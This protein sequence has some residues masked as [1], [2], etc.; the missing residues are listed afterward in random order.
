MRPSARVFAR[1]FTRV[2]FA[3]G[4]PLALSVTCAEP[5]APISVGS[6]LVSGASTTVIVGQTLQLTAEVHSEDNAVLTDR[7]VAWSANPSSVATVSTT[8]LVTTLV[9][10]SVTVTATAG[11]VSGIYNITVVPIPVATVEVTPATPTVIVGATQQLTAT[12][13]SGTGAALT[14]RVVTW[15]SATPATATVSATGLV[16]GVAVGSVVITATSETIDGTATVT[17]NPIPIASV[18]VTPV[19]DTLLPTQTVQ[20]AAQPRSATNAALTGRVVTWSS[21]NEAVAT[22]SGTGLVTAV[23]A[24]TATIR[25]TSEGVIGP[26]TIVVVPVPVASVHV[27]PAGDTILIGATTQLA[28]EARDSAG[29]VLAGRAIAW[30][31]TAV[32]TATVSGTGLV[33]GVGA[34]TALI[35]ATS[36]GRADTSTVLVSP[37]PVESVSVTPSTDSLHPAQSVQLAA[38]L[39]DSTGAEV[40]G[41][42]VSW[43]S[44]DSAVATVDASGLVTAVA[45]GAATI[46][47]TSEGVN[48]T[49]A[50]TVL[51]VPV[52]DVELTPANPIIVVGATAQLTATPRDSAG[53]A[54]AGRTVTWTS[55]DPSIAT[56]SA[57]GLVT[58]VDVGFIGIVAT[59]EGKADTVEVDVNPVPVDSLFISPARDTIIIGTTVQL[60]VTAFDST[61]AVLVGRPVSWGSITNAHASVN[62]SGLVTGTFPGTEQI[63]AHVITTTARGSTVT[64]TI[65]ALITVLPLPVDSIVIRLWNSPIEPTAFNTIKDAKTPLMALNFD[66][67]GTALFR[68]VAW[69]SRNP[70]IVTVNDTGLV[71]GVGTGTAY[72]VA[73]SEGVRDSVMVTSRVL[74][75]TEV[76]AGP[77][78]AC[79]LTTLG[80]AWCWGANT[81]SELGQAGV[82]DTTLA[83]PVSGGLTFTTL[84]HGGKYTSNIDDGAYGCGIAAGGALHCWGNNYRGQLG[85]GSASSTPADSPQAVSGGLTFAKV[86]AGNRHACGITA[87]ST[88]YCW[89]LNEL[90]YALGDSTQ[91]NRHVP[92]MVAGG[93]KWIAISAGHDFTCGLVAN[94]SAF[95]WGNDVRGQLGNGLTPPA[96]CNEGSFF[97]ASPAPV[98]G[99]LTFTQI[100]AGQSHA[101]GV[102]TDSESYCWGHNVYGQLGRGDISAGEHAGFHTPQVVTGGHDFVYVSAQQDFTCAITAAGAAYCWGMNGSYELGNGTTTMSGSPVAVVGAPPMATLSSRGGNALS[103][104]GMSI[105]GEAWCWGPNELI[106]GLGFGGIGSAHPPTKVLGQP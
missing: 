72:V 42:A 40:T 50:I 52:S 47:A 41:R 6:V 70:A 34:G 20:L 60:S 95:C 14:D 96:Q 54:L 58:G 2:A 56:V 93:H 64:D 67:A 105:A 62:A 63:K 44:S 27:T 18:E 24:G 59:S 101:C 104:C 38:T 83:I 81:T 76:H 7:P 21:L 28:A 39:F 53:G 48:G 65:S 1:R 89:G 32:G 31:S 33:T 23:G 69:T 4:A 37:L 12:P 49:A 45:V 78:S 90:T 98:V 91:V 10:G 97:C 88:A 36:E 9:T 99:G 79:A 17:V 61:G 86:S 15:V 43:S 106:R 8:G 73:E 82:F 80:D 55:L 102:A 11:G 75:F 3:L 66:S 30:S 87:D 74:V 29:G 77:E 71:T 25:A 19:L 94:G 35:V 46:T 85:T 68:P 57:T 13:K 100:S 84:T 16:T 103:T 5:T 51:A 26:A 22:V 92:T